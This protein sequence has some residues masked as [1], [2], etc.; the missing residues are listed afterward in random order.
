MMYVEAMTLEEINRRLLDGLRN[1]LIDS[2]PNGFQMGFVLGFASAMKSRNPRRPSQRQIS[3][4]RRLV[5]EIKR[6][7]PN[8]PIDLIDVG[9]NDAEHQMAMNR[10]EF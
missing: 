4:A 1:G 9:D 2:D 7:D 8:E 6:H 3:I 5:G 10:A